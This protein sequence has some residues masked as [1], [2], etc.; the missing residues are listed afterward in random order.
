MAGPLLTSKCLD[1]QLLSHKCFFFPLLSPSSG[2]VLI[3]Q[4]CWS[5]TGASGHYVYQNVC[6]CSLL[7]VWRSLEQWKMEL[8]VKYMLEDVR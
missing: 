8:L 5:E 3:H 2:K 7:S 4:F 6:D 1:L